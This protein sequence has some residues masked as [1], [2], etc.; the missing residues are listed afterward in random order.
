MRYFF[1]AFFVYFILLSGFSVNAAD[2]EDLKE[3]LRSSG[4]QELSKNQTLVE[5][6]AENEMK[7]N[8][9]RQNEATA[10]PKIESAIPLEGP[11]ASAEGNASGEAFLSPQP[12]PTPVQSPT[13]LPNPTETS[14]PQRKN[15]KIQFDTDDMIISVD[16]DTVTNQGI[17]KLLTTSRGLE[18]GKTVY[19]YDFEKAETIFLL[20]Q[21][22]KEDVSRVSEELYY[23]EGIMVSP[24]RRYVP[25]REPAYSPN[26]P[27]YSSQWNLTNISYSAALDNGNGVENI[28][29]GVMDNGVNTSETDLINRLWVNTGE[30]AGNGIDDDANGY[31]DDIYGCNFYQRHTLN[32]T[33][34]PCSTTKIFSS[35]HGKNV[36]SIIAA[37][38]NNS[39]GIAG[40]CPN[41]RIMVLDVD[42]AGGAAL[43]NVIFAIDYAVE[44]GVDI[45]NFSYAA[46]CPFPVEQDVLATTLD[47]LINTHGVYYVQSASNYGSRTTSQCDV[48]C[49]SSSYC[50]TS[51]KNE[52]Y[53]YVD[54]KEVEN[55]IIVAAIDQSSKRASF[56]SYDGSNPVID[57]AAPGVSVPVSNSTLATVNG[58]SFSAPHVVG[59]IGY[60]LSH[61]KTSLNPSIAS[62]ID[63]M[64]AT[65]DEINTDKNISGKKL[66]LQRFYD[67]MNAKDT[68]RN[69]NYLYITRFYS[70]SLSSHFYTGS[71]N[72]F[73]QIINTYPDD[74][75][76]FE[77]VAYYA[78]ASQAAGSSPVYR[79]WSPV[80]KSHFYTISEAE[81]NYVQNE[82]NKF[83]NFE[84]IAFYA[85]PSDEPGQIPVYRF[86][87]SLFGKHF[88]TTST[89][90]RDYLI[91][92]FPDN[93][94]KYEYASWSV[95]NV[96]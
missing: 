61:F 42:D 20:V 94:W 32:N 27:F 93:V 22:G 49:S 72:E 26:D 35:G 92:D 55:N 12:T 33:T 41:C 54:G 16:I 53:Y 64:T 21:D 43:S 28:I 88:Y 87:S 5:Q 60:I 14:F 18:Q 62:V 15:Q 85:Y 77:Y 71:E 89:A 6:V 67:L 3:K 95:P 75:W 79:F 29:V 80:Y 70:N 37:E 31:I 59:A 82:L 8:R 91:N 38:S 4:I 83:W 58:T 19:F 69:T 48:D 51:A 45:I 40:I 50:S 17:E 44:K 90:E 56:S 34:D 24:N 39:Y 73:L 68:V 11:V 76:N 1:P 63:F 57:I 46:A 13:A 52:A 9:L 86:W 23:E 30:T 65:G 2:R 36:A 96:N 7:I 25:T 84:G 66:N 47:S 74:V 81:R 78:F 10:T